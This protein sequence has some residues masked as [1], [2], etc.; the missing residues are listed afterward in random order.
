MTLTLGRGVSP[1]EPGQFTNLALQVAGARCRRSYSL[2]SGQGAPC[3]FYIAKVPGGGLTPR[4]FEL[5]EGSEVE[6]EDR[7][8]GFFTLRHLPPA[9]RLW[10]LATGTGLGPY[11][12]L[13]R[14]P[15]VW[16]YAEEIAVVHGAR[17]RS[18]L[19]YEQEL[20]ARVAER[21]G[22]LHYVPVLSRDA[23][24]PDGLRGRIT[25]ALRGGSLEQRLQK[26][27]GPEQDHVMLCGNPA[28]I[29]EVQALL[30]ERGMRKHRK[31]AP[32]HLTFESYW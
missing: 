1:F 11:I 25:D 32:G 20:R 14:S 9:R 22:R 6:L 31:R 16:Q 3:E 21:A 5:R 7:G 24:P 13:L 19:G 26:R 8:L 4:L 15:G 29:E 28:M 27:L 17:E 2:A 12:S 10:M 23:A 18:Q 30:A